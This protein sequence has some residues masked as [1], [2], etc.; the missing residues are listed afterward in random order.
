[1][2]RG[3]SRSQQARMVF[4]QTRAF[5]EGR[6]HHFRRR[7]RSQQADSVNHAALGD[8]RTGGPICCTW[9]DPRRAHAL[10]PL[11]IL[12]DDPDPKE[13]W[14]QDRR[15][16]ALRTSLG[17]GRRARLVALGSR[18]PDPLYG[19]ARMLD[20]AA[21]QSE[22]GRVQGDTVSA[23][24]RVAVDLGR[25]RCFGRISSGPAPSAS[26]GTEALR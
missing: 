13:Y 25:S 1:M 5:L 4:D 21:G 19:F 15:P 23:E 11:L 6:G 18:P 26:T 20:G 10:A 14:K 8:R 17:K 24:G 2:A 22:H 3:A 9:S 12:R 16:S 7:R